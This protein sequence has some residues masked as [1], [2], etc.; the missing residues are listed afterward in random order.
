MFER[1]R[2]KGE[3]IDI[4]LNNPDHILAPNDPDM[5]ARGRFEKITPAEYKEWYMALIKERWASR[6]A[7]FIS[8]ATE[9][10]NK[11]I[12]LKCFCADT[13]PYC[14]GKI[15]VNFMNALLKKFPA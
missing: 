6:K 15:A 7:E 8:L 5:V 3:G 9:G 14:H 12:K 2:I 11:T 1:E 4:S 13:S 10:R